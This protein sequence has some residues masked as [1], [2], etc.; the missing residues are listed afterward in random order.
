MTDPFPTERAK[1]HA[2]QIMD[3]F[4][5]F[6]CIDYEGSREIGIDYLFGSARGQMFGVLVCKDT[7]G[8]EVVLK[9]FSGQ[10]NG[11]YMIEG[12]VPPALDTTSYQTIVDASV[13]SFNEIERKIEE[14]CGDTA[15]ISRLEASRKL[16]SQETQRRI[17][18]LYR[19]CCADSSVKTLE[20]IFSDRMP[21]TGTGDCCAPK[22][23]SHA[24][25]NGLLPISMVE[26]YY[27][28]PNRSNGRENKHFYPPCE[29][30]CKP[31]LEAILGIDI[32]YRDEAI[33]VVN[34]PSGLLSVPGRGEDKQ[35]CIVSRVKRLYP[36]CIEQPSVHR[37][38]MDTSGLLVLAFTQQ[39]HR[40]L[41]IQFIKRQVHKQYIALVE[42]VVSIDEGRIELAFRYDPERKPRQKYDPVLGKWGTTLWEKIRVEPFGT[43]GRLVSRLRFTPLTG[44]THQL[45]LHSA[46]EKGLAH[47]IVGD[48]LYGTGEAASRLMLH[49]YR[50]E[51]IH[52]ETKES[53]HFVVEPD[54]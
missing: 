38:D 22:L 19:L 41:S 47:P 51:F 45:R 11:Q 52:P 15:I 3:A 1:F 12:W 20:D 33:I 13:Q 30:R 42:G 24:Y 18:Q 36:L 5:T 10:Y 21:P 54:F 28:A 2:R 32:I 16:L 44:R 53:L 25:K 26:W 34:K 17:F 27:G 50:L 46:H 37:L 23:L 6:G 48:P 8:N 14:F 40:E 35:D 9:A 49:A 29:E 7:L 43:D 31:L 39:A 4:E